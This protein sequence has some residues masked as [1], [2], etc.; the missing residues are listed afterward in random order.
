MLLRAIKAA[1]HHFNHRKNQYLAV[2]EAIGRFW[3]LCQ[4]KDMSN[5]TFHDKFKAIVSVVKEQGGN[6]A[7][8]T[9]LIVLEQAEYSSDEEDDKEDMLDMEEL[10]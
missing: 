3:I 9:L 2:A 1:M 7:I 4:G 6:I 10:E 5:Q 8:H